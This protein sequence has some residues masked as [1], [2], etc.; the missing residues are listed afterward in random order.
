[1]TD[2]LRD[3]STAYELDLSSHSRAHTEVFSPEAS[4]R[5][6]IQWRRERLNRLGKGFLGTSSGHDSIHLKE[7]ET[8]ELTSKE[9][10][11]TGERSV[12]FWCIVEFCIDISNQSPFLSES[13]FFLRLCEEENS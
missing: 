2:L 3:V 7:T 8:T 1:M 11:S 13:M 4:W 12:C 9:I 6:R 10:A 5:I